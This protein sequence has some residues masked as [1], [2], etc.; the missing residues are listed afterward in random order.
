MGKVLTKEPYDRHK[1]K[2]K[3]LSWM[4]LE[5]GTCYYKIYTDNSLQIPSS[6]NWGAGLFFS[7]K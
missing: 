2:D 5:T 4:F 1:S 7:V 3:S 6:E